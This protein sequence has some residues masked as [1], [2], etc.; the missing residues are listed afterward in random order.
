MTVTPNQG[1]RGLCGFDPISADRGT[2]VK[3]YESSDDTAAKV[4]LHLVEP[5]SFDDPSGRE[6]A[7]QLDMDALQTL[8]D[9]LS[10]MIENHFMVRA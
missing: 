6:I 5:P 4:Y 1:Q 9:E 10:W 2:V 8:H 3:V 7:A